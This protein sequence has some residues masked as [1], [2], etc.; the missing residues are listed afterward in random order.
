MIR[1]VGTKSPFRRS[2]SFMSIGLFG[3]MLSAAADGPSGVNLQIVPRDDIE[4]SQGA[5]FRFDLKAFN[6]GPEEVDIEVRLTLRSPSPRDP[7]VE[8]RR[9]DVTVPPG[10]TAK[11]T[12]SVTPAQ[13]FASLGRFH[14]AATMVG[15]EAG[16]TLEFDV[17]ESAVVVPKFQDVTAA[18][19]LETTLGEAGCAQFSAG[20]AWGDIERDGDLDLYVPL[21]DEAAR[22]WVNDGAGVL[23]TRP[24]SEVPTTMEPRAWRR[25]SPTT[26]TMAIRTFT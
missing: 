4:V 11:V 25:C 15:E 1:A 10:G 2:L 14:I 8:F 3:V 6:D 22:L 26:T 19:G 9:W 24:A 13:W 20:A 23:A 16:P 21:Q 5:P 18:S 12:L 7:L 17:L